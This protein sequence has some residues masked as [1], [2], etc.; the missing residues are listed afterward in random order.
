MQEIRRLRSEGV[1]AELFTLCKNQLYGELIADLENIDDVAA[2]LF[3][4]FSRGRT[5]AE[6][7]DTLAA[8][9]LEDV[10]GALQNLLQ[11]E[12]SA[13]VIIRPAGEKKGELA[14]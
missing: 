13:T 1:D 7:I 8:I 12:Y 5:P 9:T 4:A 14:S 3:S 10:N 11:E 2:G 6:E